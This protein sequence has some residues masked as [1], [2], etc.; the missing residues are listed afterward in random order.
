MATV[1][2]DASLALR[3][4][5][6]Q[7]AAEIRHLPKVSGDRFWRDWRTLR[8]LAYTPNGHGEVRVRFELLD[9]QG[10]VGEGVIRGSFMEHRLASRK[11]QQD[12]LEARLKELGYR[13]KPEVA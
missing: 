6:D 3:S 10:V 7:L 13:C 1:L 5:E 9:Q 11:T 2:I 8:L 12:K 4:F